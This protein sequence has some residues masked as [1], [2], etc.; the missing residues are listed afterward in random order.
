LKKI[1]TRLKL[2]LVDAPEPMYRIALRTNIN[3][4]RLSR[5]STGLFSPTENE[6][7]KLS[8]ILGIPS[9]ELFKGGE[10]SL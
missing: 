3:E 4:T 7:Q 2:A 8:E 9:D 6:K 5:L 1:I 10:I